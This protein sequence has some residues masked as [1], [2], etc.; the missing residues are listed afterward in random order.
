M[1]VPSIVALAIGILFAVLW[2]TTRLWGT[3]LAAI[4]WLLYAPYELLMHLR[5]LCSGECNI[6]VDLL[7]LW[8]LL[9]LVSVAVPGRYLSQRMKAPRRR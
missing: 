7:L 6:R 2:M 1:L 9:L 8:P 4:C 5:V 3:A